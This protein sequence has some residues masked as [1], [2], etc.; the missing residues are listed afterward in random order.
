MTKF[1]IVL[2]GAEAEIIVRVLDETLRRMFNEAVQTAEGREQMF[3]VMRPYVHIKD[4]LDDA[5]EG[6]AESRLGMGAV[7]A[8]FAGFPVPPPP[9][10]PA[11]PIPIPRPGP[12]GHGIGTGIG[13]CS[14]CGAAFPGHYLS[15]PG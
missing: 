13:T 1:T 8:S 9:P 5:R 10:P 2:D 12:G 11:P 15:C 14:K 3:E 6:S 7:P 4:A